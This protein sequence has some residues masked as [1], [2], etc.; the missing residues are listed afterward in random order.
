MPV[1]AYF[2]RHKDV[3][4]E[5]EMKRRQNNGKNAEIGSDVEQPHF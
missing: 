3:T 5:R 2:H 4:G 1:F